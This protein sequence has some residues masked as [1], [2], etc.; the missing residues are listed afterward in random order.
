MRTPNQTVTV[1][2]NWF[3]RLYVGC[4]ILD[5]VFRHCQRRKQA[6]RYKSWCCLSYTC[7][8]PCRWIELFLWIDDPF[9]THDPFAAPTQTADVDPVQH[10]AWETVNPR[11][12]KF[13]R[14]SNCICTS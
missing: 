11:Y 6:G 8:F 7:C 13:D 1:Y 12:F 14:M 4:C 2:L 3:A 10:S 5:M 9:A